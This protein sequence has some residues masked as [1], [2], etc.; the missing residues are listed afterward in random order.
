MPRLLALT[1][2]LAFIL[3]GCK[4]PGATWSATETSAVVKLGTTSFELTLEY[5]SNAIAAIAWHFDSDLLAATPASGTLTPGQQQAVVVNLREPLTAPIGVPMSGTFF[6]GRSPLSVSFTV[7]CTG[8]PLPVQAL[9]L[10]VEYLVG[11]AASGD[12]SEGAR[13]A[14]A[15]AVIALGGEV[16]RRGSGH[17]HDLVALP[18]G[19]QASDRATIRALP[20]VAYLEANAA[21]FPMASIGGAPNDPSFVHQW[22]LRRF[23]V[24]GG[25]AIA[26]GITPPHRDIVVAVI[27]TGVATDHPD[28]AGRLVPG[29]DVKENNPEVRNCIDHGT[30]VA[31]IVAAARGNGE[32]IAGVASVPWVKVLPV[33]AWPTSDRTLGTTVD[34][35]V[36]AMRWAAGLSV[37]DLPI[38]P[39][40][41]DILNLSLGGSGT[42]ASRALSDAVKDVNDA[43]VAVIAA[44]GN[45]G[46]SSNPAILYPAAAVGAIAVGSV[47]FDYRRS[48]F[49]NFGPELSLMAP[50]GEAPEF[51]E[52]PARY[53]V[54]T[55]ITIEQGRVLPIYACYSGTSMATPYVA[56]AAALLLG[57]RPAELLGNPEK[58]REELEAAAARYR[59][60]SYRSDRYGNGILCL[61]SLL[62]AEAPCG[63]P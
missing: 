36:R 5:P 41:A 39:H 3:V 54:S 14:V 21:V 61:D 38:N 11:Y 9:S 28:L 40:P 45:N 29:Y 17:E 34:D 19:A 43:G 1:L 12:A 63:T 16:L 27:D 47:D 48:A 60:S 50:G 33:K 49:S 51:G 42:E 2:G 8:S 44:A 35:V 13:D 57:Q 32:G 10:R 20:G 46:T 52:C 30:H 59:P 26:D 7:T 31:G 23:G 24:E 62:G 22:N 58:L 6:G 25:W 15:A 4:H 55:G 53:V 37:T 18:T 56:G